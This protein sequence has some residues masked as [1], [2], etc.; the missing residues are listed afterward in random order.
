MRRLEPSIFTS[1]IEYPDAAANVNVTECP[2]G[3]DPY[4]DMVEC[5][6]VD[7]T[8]VTAVTNVIAPSVVAHIRMNLRI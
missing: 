3:T 2:Y 8:T 1:D 5:T 4:G 7:A 6:S